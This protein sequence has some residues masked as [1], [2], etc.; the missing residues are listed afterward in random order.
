[1]DDLDL[2]ALEMDAEL[3]RDILPFWPRF[4]DPQNGGFYGRVENDGRFEDRANKGLVMHARFLWTYAA[5]ARLLHDQ[6]LLR[7][8][9]AAY[10]FLT[11]KLYDLEH[12]GFYWITDYLGQALSMDRKVIYGQAFA[13]Y[14]LAEYARASGSRQALDLSMETFGLL[15]R[16]ARDANNGGYFEACARDWSHTVASAL[17]DVDL[18]CEKSM[19]T[20]LHVMEALSALYAA[21]RDS[22]VLDALRRLIEIHLDRILA[23]GGHLGLFFKRDWSR[24]DAAVSFGHDIEASWLLTE[25]AQIAWEGRIPDRVKDAALGIAAVSAGVLEENEGCLPNE[26]KEGRLDSE[27]IWWV[28]AE[29]IVGMVNAWELSGDRAYLRLAAAAWRFVKASIIDREHGEW[30]WGAQAN[31]V[32]LPNRPKGGLWKASYHNARA[33]MEI[34]TRAARSK[35]EPA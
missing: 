9:E 14:A 10:R 24:M 8:A 20:H 4:M 11:E 5:A 31:G 30:L 32:P 21:C 26:L 17:S 3:R 18:R 15:E 28:Q 19:N 1:M 29:A 12:K 16:F 22:D 6:S 33:C 34:M 25:A 23:S 7:T 35:K 13:A 27:R 2:L